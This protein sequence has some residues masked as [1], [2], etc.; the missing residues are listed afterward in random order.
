LAGAEIFKLVFHTDL[1]KRAQLLNH[2]ELDIWNFGR[3]AATAPPSNLMIP[4]THLFGVGAVTHGLLWIIERWPG[5]VNGEELLLIDHDSY[6]SSNGQRYAG[7]RVEFDGRSKAKEKETTL[8]AAHPGLKSTGIQIDGDAYFDNHERHPNVQLAVVGVDSKEMRRHVA[9]KLPRRTVNM[10]TEQ[11][12]VGSARMGGG[13]GWPCLMC[14]YPEATESSLDEVARISKAT[15][16][17]LHR[18]RELIDGSGVLSVQ[19]ADAIRRHF[20]MPPESVL[21]RTL[22]TVM[23]EMC[24]TGKLQLPGEAQAVDVPFAFA[25]MLAGVAGFT[26]LVQELAN[27]ECDPFD[28]SFDV[29]NRLGPNFA[30]QAS[31]RPDCMLCA[32]GYGAA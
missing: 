24:S 31:P 15:T 23:H 18:V 20:S 2:L 30:T 32:Q 12:Y 6:D 27:F 7:M 13:D 29:L 28:W 10:W 25:S 26:N 16:I 14:Q 17:P 11:S 19:D 4:R 3:A 1:A 9:L 21:G 22:N 8:R 5:D